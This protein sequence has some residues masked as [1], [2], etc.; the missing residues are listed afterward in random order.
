MANVRLTFA[1]GA[2]ADITASR[3]TKDTVRKIRIFQEE[4]YI[5]LD[6]LHQDA[7]LFKKTDSKLMK[8]RIKIKK[9]EPLKKEL[10]SFLECIRANTKPIVSG[11]EGRKALQVALSILN[12][13]SP[14]KGNV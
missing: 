4:S 9:E 14:V 1:N 5:S 7:T 8:K 13:I 11:T 6:Y 10:E 12:K 2:I 3:V